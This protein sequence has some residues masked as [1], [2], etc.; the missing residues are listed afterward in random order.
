M[1]TTNVHRRDDAVKMD[2]TQSKLAGSLLIPSGDAACEERWIRPWGSTYAIG[3][4]GSCDVQQSWVEDFV[5]VGSTAPATD[6]D[7]LL[8]ALRD[9]D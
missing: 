7:D 4:C 3:G 9:R 1:Y 2:L 6:E 8:V 5:G